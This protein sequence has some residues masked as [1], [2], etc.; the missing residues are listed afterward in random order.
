VK[1]LLESG[2]DVNKVCTDGESPLHYATERN[3]L[4]LVKLLVAAGA[5][6]NLEFRG[7]TALAIAKEE[8]HTEIARYLEMSSSK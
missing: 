7:K 4:E 5:N 8:K 3:R 6:L 2:A 1:L